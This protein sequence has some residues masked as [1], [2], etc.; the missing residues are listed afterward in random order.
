MSQHALTSFGRGRGGGP[1]RWGVTRRRGRLVVGGARG[2]GGG[3]EGTLWSIETKLFGKLL[4]IVSMNVLEYTAS[5]HLHLVV[6]KY[7][8][9]IVSEYHIQICE[10]QE[11]ITD[12]CILY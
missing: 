8:T 12:Q 10:N 7:I 3:E 11:N 5:G 1:R 2:R 4:V 9:R 6:K